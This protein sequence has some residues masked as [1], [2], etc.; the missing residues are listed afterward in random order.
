MRQADRMIE[1][2]R[3]SVESHLKVIKLVPHKH[4]VADIRHEVD[5]LWRLEGHKTE[6]LIIDSPDLMMPIAKYK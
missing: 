1:V 6:S 4:T 2:L 3:D 5:K